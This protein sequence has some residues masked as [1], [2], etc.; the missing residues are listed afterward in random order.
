M[1]NTIRI[2][3]S[4]TIGVRIDS[5]SQIKMD[6][7]NKGLA[8]LQINKIDEFIEAFYIIVLENLNRNTLILE[9]WERTISVSSVGISPVIKKLSNQQKQALIK[10]G[11]QCTAKYLCK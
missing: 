2:P 4:K 11:E 8:P 1:K 5:D 7:S 9:D 3:N 10:S 6:K